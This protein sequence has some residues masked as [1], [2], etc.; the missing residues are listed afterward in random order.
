MSI[1]TDKSSSSSAYPE[2]DDKPSTVD[3]GDTEDIYIPYEGYDDGYGPLTV[4][5]ANDIK[6]YDIYMES[7]RMLPR[8]GDYRQAARFVGVSR[9]NIEHNI[10][11]FDHNL[12]LNTKVYDVMFP[13]VSVHRYAANTI[14]MNIYSQVDEDSHRYQLIDYISN[15]KSDVRAVLKSEEF[16]VSRNGN[17]A[18]KQTTKG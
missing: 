4:P 17:M 13:D 9:I 11:E 10:G 2:H 3:S 5:E 12:I 8:D 14:S 16:T 6:Y 1:P 18:R 15:H 7:E